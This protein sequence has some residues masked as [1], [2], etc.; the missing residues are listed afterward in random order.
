MAPTS[1]PDRLAALVLTGLLVAGAAAGAE[2]ESDPEADAALR[3]RIEARL[4]EL[5]DAVGPEIRVRVQAGRGL[6]QG[7]V[8]LLEHA[9]RPGQLT[10][11][12]PGV[13]DVRIEAVLLAARPFAARPAA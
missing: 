8:A 12:T 2:P 1:R 7:R 5:P 4:A 6:L 9:L 10:W 3:A 11:T 13:R